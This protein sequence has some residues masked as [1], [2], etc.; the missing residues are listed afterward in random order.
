MFHTKVLHKIKT[1]TFFFKKKEN[2]TVYAIMWENIV[3]P[4]RQQMT[5]HSLHIAC[6]IPKSTNTHS[7]Y[8]I[9]IAFPLQH[10]LYECTS[11]FH[12]THIACLVV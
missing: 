2:C 8:A 1:H 10:W 6:K 12:C 11:I 5:I 7:Q 9:H 3:V 4:D